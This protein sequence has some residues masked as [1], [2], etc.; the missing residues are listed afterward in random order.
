MENIQE[1]YTRVS[2]ILS[3]LP[4]LTGMDDNN[5]KIWG[6]P[7]Q[8]I[9]QEV[10]RKKCIIGTN[11]HAAINGW[12]I[13]DFSPLTECE[14]GYFNS[15]LRW[16]EIMHIKPIASELRLYDD[17]L[18]ITGAIDMLAKI[19]ASDNLILFDFKTSALVDEKKWPLQA[20][21]YYHLLC[22]NKFT[23]QENV[24]FIQLNRKGD[25]PHCHTYFIDNKLKT[26]MISAYNIYKHLTEK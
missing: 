10:L 6:F 18:K 9:N 1:G 26:L 21:F 3:V 2:T 14:N 4:S 22:V 11:V 17:K 25:L 24:L 7:F 20:A 5:Q 13:N 8:N 19:P 15:F 16:Q 23:A 12:A